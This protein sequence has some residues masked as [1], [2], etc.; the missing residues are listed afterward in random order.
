MWKHA[1]EVEETATGK[2]FWLCKLCHEQ[3][4]VDPRDLA[5]PVRG[6]HLTTFPYI[7]GFLYRRIVIIILNIYIYIKLISLRRNRQA[8]NPIA[9][10]WSNQHR[11]PRF[12]RFALD[13]LAI[14][15]MSAEAE[16]VFSNTGNM[17]RPNRACLKADIIRASAYLKQWDIVEQLSGSR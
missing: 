1:H 4:D 14:P 11:W 13:L 2:K 15:A 17:V 16:R 8:D 5:T 9:Y 12:A 3:E 7:Y 6:G 10:W